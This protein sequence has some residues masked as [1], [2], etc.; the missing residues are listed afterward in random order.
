MESKKEEV[1]DPQTQLIGLYNYF[2]KFMEIP[3]IKHI[4]TPYFEHVLGDI[5]GLDVVDLA[6]GAGIHTR[7]LRKKTKGNVVGIDNANLVAV[8]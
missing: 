7:I 2:A 4:Q 6:C 3:F 5:S 8:A 1:Q